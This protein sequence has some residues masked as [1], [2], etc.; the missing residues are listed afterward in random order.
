MIW[1]NE[2]GML[3]VTGRHDPVIGTVWIAR[4]TDDD[5]PY[6]V[7]KV[8]GFFT[9]RE[10]ITEVTFAPHGAFGVTQS[11]SADDFLTAYRIRDEAI[12]RVE[13]RIAQVAGAL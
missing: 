12:E 13:Q 7:V 6:T 10:G 9:V 3:S 2:D 8:L 1:S 5:D 11:A 4:E